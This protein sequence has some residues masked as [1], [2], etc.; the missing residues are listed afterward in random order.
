[1]K[2]L[3]LFSFLLVLIYLYMRSSRRCKENMTQGKYCHN[4]NI[5]S[6]NACLDCYNCGIRDNKCVNGTFVDENIDLHN[7]SLW[8]FNKN[9][10]LP[11]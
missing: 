6:T 2:Y 11:Y 7:D 9:I 8:K 10:I 1:M 5:L 3:L 4:C